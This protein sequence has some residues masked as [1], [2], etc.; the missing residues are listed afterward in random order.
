MAAQSPYAQALAEN[1]DISLDLMQQ[2]QGAT[3][4]VIS[5]RPGFAPRDAALQKLVE[6]AN[7]RRQGLQVMD[8]KARLAMPPQRQQKFAG[9]EKLMD[10][11]SQALGH[12]TPEQQLDSRIKTDDLVFKM[13]LEQELQRRGVKPGEEFETL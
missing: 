3:Q 8:A 6:Q 1:P 5:P 10:A 7:M 12:G 2:M 11:T 9:W 13:W 4:S